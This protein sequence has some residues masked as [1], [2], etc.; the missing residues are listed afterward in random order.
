[1]HSESSMS[2]D[3]FICPPKRAKELTIAFLLARKIRS[4]EA[5]DRRH[6]YGFTVEFASEWRLFTEGD[7]ERV[8]STE[9]GVRTILTLAGHP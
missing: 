6:C 8:R 5:S 4:F 2:A 7:S 1:M 9:S 3:G